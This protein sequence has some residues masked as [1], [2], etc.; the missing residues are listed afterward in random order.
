MLSLLG[1]PV[2]CMYS[3]SCR[4]IIVEDIFPRWEIRTDVTSH[5]VAFALFDFSDM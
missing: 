1:L 3:L 2:Q 5:S 4:A